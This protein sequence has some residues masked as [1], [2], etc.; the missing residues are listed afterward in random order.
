MVHLALAAP[1]G[2]SVCALLGE[3]ATKAAS[4]VP[5]E[6]VWVRLSHARAEGPIDLTEEDDMLEACPVADAAFAAAMVGFEG[7]VC[8]N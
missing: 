5:A 7:Q 6:L 2:K 4:H 3:N 8:V 1:I